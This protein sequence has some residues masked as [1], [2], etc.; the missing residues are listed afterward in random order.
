MSD[1]LQPLDPRTAVDLYL[2]HREPELSKS[3]IQNQR[4]RLDSFVEWCEDE[5]IENINRLT[6]RNLHQFRVWRRQGRGESHGPVSKVTLRGILATV[7]MFL[8]FCATIDAVEEGLR[9]KVMLPNVSAAEASREEKLDEDDAD[10]I[11][12]H[13]ER[14]QYAGREHVIFSVLWHTGIRLGTLRGFDLRDFSYEQQSMKVRHRPESDTPLKNQEA[15]ERIIAV[16]EHYCDVIQ[17]YIDHN[18]VNTTDDYG[19]EPLIT[20]V[21]GRIAGGTIRNYVYQWTRPCMLRGCPHD[22]DP[23]TC[24]AMKSDT[25]GKCPSSRSPHGVRRGSITTHLRD[26]VPEEIVS[27]RM[28]A[29]KEVL[30]Q[31]YDKRTERERMELRREFLTDK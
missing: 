28:N 4:Y 10:A 6:G 14:F 11:I 13:L 29:S 21:Q 9:E 2:D 18:R 7:R 23:D 30:E 16:G 12:D 20:T 19:R 1:K 24:E 22:R 27:D 26:G 8:E 15:A 3:S 25:A 5:D 17:D 31:H